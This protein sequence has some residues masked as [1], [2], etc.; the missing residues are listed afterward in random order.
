MMTLNCVTSNLKNSR[1]K[2]PGE[3]HRGF[4]FSWQQHRNRRRE[5]TP[6]DGH[7]RSHYSAVLYTDNTGKQQFLHSNNI[8]LSINRIIHVSRVFNLGAAKSRG[9]AFGWGESPRRQLMVISGPPP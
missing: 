8:V 5:W 4:V 1:I 6:N 7:F 9:N 3:N 2:K